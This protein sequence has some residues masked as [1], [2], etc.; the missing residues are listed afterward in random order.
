MWQFDGDLEQGSCIWVFI[1]IVGVIMVMVMAM[2]RLLSVSIGSAGKVGRR[3]LGI[4]SFYRDLYSISAAD[5]EGGS[6]SA[7]QLW[8]SR[9][10]FAR[11]LEFLVRSVQCYCTGEDERVWEATDAT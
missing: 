7:H 10:H 3:S 5:Q 6:E 8:S 1:V 9:H 4:R 2:R 11:P